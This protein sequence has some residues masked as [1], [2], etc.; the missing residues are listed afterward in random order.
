MGY[1][2]APGITAPAPGLNTPYSC[3]NQVLPVGCE[4]LNM[5]WTPGAQ[6]F[7]APPEAGF[8]AGQ[9]GP[10]VL[11]LQ[12]HY[13]NPGGVVGTVRAGGGRRPMATGNQQG[14]GGE[15]SY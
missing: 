13:Q 15:R 7:E 4:T 5:V 9:G 6:R 1:V 8:A 11:V 2:C 12:V 3:S 14:G 10:A